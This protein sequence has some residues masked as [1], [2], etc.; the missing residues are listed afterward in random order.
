MGYVSGDGRAGVGWL[1]TPRAPAN[2][3]VCE[4]EHSE[5]ELRYSQRMQRTLPAILLLAALALTGC[6]A[7][8]LLEEPTAPSAP[9]EATE[10]T[11][12]ATL[13]EAASAAGCGDL[14]PSTS[15][16]EAPVIESG[17]CKLDDG[18]EL[19]FL[20]QF[21]DHDTAEGWLNS[22]AL[23]VGATDAVYVDGAVVLMARDAATA[24]AFAEVAE[25]FQP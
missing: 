13:E 18:A 11:G 14:R 2:A 25:P 4:R 5:R 15:G 21:E 23:E 19:A 7:Q 6:T 8:T 1:G 3:G 22:G 16:D 24:Q 12:A 9:S 10:N 20:W 17:T